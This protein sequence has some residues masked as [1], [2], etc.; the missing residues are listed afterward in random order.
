MTLMQAKINSL[1]RSIDVS[2][3]KDQQL[4]KQ[5]ASIEEAQ[6]EAERKK[7]A[8]QEFNERCDQVRLNKYENVTEERTRRR[9]A[10]DYSHASQQAHIERVRAK[11]AHE[12]RQHDESVKLTREH[13]AYRKKATRDKML[14]DA[15][16]CRSVRKNEEVVFMKEISTVYNRERRLRQAHVQQNNE[17][18]S[19]L[20]QTKREL[21]E[22]LLHT[23][24][25]EIDSQRT[26][27]CS[28]RGR[29]TS[30]HIEELEIT[31]SAYQHKSVSLK[32]EEVDRATKSTKDKQVLKEMILTT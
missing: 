28:Y 20:E 6:R 31:T 14:S 13:L 11:S 29:D 9:N 7:R 8:R 10:A 21:E 19:E 1:K 4:R 5:K 2:G 30:R 24:R 22:R 23:K 18:L 3:K 27:G 25:V 17:M 12:R 16:Y 15:K 32:I 26:L